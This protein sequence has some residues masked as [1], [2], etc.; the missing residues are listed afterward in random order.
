MWVAFQ[1]C[2]KSEKTALLIPAGSWF[3]LQSSVPKMLLLELQERNIRDRQ[4]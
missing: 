3:N 4:I 2:G 1:M